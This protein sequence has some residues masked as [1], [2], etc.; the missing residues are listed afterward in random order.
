MVHGCRGDGGRHRSCRSGRC[1]G[2]G[3]SSSGGRRRGDGG[4]H[5][6]CRSGRC[7]GGGHD[8]FHSVCGGLGDGRCI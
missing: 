7:V 6:S 1:V 3:H 2:G 4:R 5:R 8:G